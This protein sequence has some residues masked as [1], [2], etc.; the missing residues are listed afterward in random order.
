MNESYLKMEANEEAF[1]SIWADRVGICKDVYLLINTRM[2]S[3]Y[4]YN[5]LNLYNGE[6]SC[7]VLKRAEYRFFRNN[8]NC[9]AYVHEK[10]ADTQRKL[11]LAGFSWIDTMDVLTLTLESDFVDK[12]KATTDVS[13]VKVNY[14]DIASWV[15][16]FCESFEILEMQ[17]EIKQRIERHFDKLILLISY[18][19]SGLSAPQ[20][21]GCCALFVNRG[22]IGVYCLGTI[23]KFRGRGIARKMLASG[24]Q[25]TFNLD[26]LFL[27]TFESQNLFAFY[28]KFG[29]K[30][31]YKKRVFEKK[32]RDGF[33]L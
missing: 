26:Y 4:F 30:L 13:V 15:S 20:I 18:V 28:R 33:I 14:A 32:Y 3:D 22:I 1:C 23:P 8:M 5:R 17:T 25:Y 6:I 12:K 2:P 29:F 31:A 7:E 21:G 10:N 16:A 11:N 24:V 9:Y 19:C 27:Q